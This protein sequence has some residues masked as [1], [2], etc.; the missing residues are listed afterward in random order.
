MPGAAWGVP[1]NGSPRR[2]AKLRSRW[3]DRPLPAIGAV[4]AAQGQTL[5]TLPEIRYSMQSDTKAM[6]KLSALGR[7][8]ED[9]VTGLPGEMAGEGV[10][11][12]S[13]M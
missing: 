7:T 4:T 12:L 5:A 9:R 1:P 8:D 2:D 10:A 6:G 13:R 3:W 11:Q